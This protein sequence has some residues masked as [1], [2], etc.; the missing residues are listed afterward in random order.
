MP[1]VKPLLSPTPAVEAVS[2]HQWHTG[3]EQLGRHWLTWLTLCTVLI[4]VG[5]AYQYYFFDAPLRVLL[6]DE[7]LLS[8]LV[9]R[10]SGRSWSEV[11]TDAELSAQISTVVR[12][13]ALLVLLGAVA[14]GLRLRRPHQ[15][16]QA[17]IWAAWLIC[18]SYVVLERL[19]SLRSSGTFLSM[20]FS[21]ARRC[22]CSCSP[23]LG[24]AAQSGWVLP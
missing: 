10:L 8:S 21:L 7:S 16:L 24:W 17:L 22:C 19:I 14:A 3:H 15:L 9:E 4:F 12:G 1:P 23:A 20:P 11:V 5:R 13:S 2:D 6:W 18:S